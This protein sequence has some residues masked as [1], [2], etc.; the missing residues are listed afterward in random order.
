MDL[1]SITTQKE[2]LG[3]HGVSLKKH[4]GQN[5]LLEKK[6]SAKMLVAADLSLK[7]TVYEIGPGIGTLTKELAK[8]SGKVIAIEKDPNMVKILK[9][10]TKEFSNIEI[11]QGNA[12]K[13]SPPEGKYKVI[14]NLP[15]YITSPIIRMFLETEHKP[16]CMVLMVQKEVAKRICS[17]PPHMNLLAASVQFYSDVKTI[18]TVGKGSFWPRPK[19]DSAIVQIIPKKKLPTV[20]SDL[21]F[22]VMKTGFV[23]P[24]KQLLNNF[25]KGLSLARSD[26]ESWL[27]QSGIPPTKRAETLSIEDWVSLA[28]SL[29]K[30]ALTRPS[31]PQLR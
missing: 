6:A 4:L 25:C 24:R 7:D 13:Q 29:P 1:Y 28:T 8:N 21:F 11:I 19:V 12:L 31:Y 17:K 27:K 2:L 10:T 15:Y 20:S 18:A 14:A 9:E 22:Y 30:S 26:V 16:E 3:A 23:Q 5:F